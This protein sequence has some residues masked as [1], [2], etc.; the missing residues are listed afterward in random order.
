MYLGVGD[1]GVIIDDGVH[2]RVSQ[3]F[4]TVAVTFGVR[5]G[6]SVLAAL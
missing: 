6:A 2:E 5:G 4:V 3:Q 1:P